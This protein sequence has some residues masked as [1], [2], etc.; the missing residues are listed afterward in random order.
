MCTN[1][2]RVSSLRDRT[3]FIRGTKRI[4]AVRAIIL[5]ISLAVI[6]REIR[7]DLRTDANA[8]ADF[9]GLHALASLDDLA[10]DLVADADW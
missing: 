6:A 5:L 2:R 7:L 8:V 3:V 4:N 1:M 10:D 9:N